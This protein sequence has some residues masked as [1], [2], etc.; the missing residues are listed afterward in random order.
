[1]ISYQSKAFNKFALIVCAVF[2]ALPAIASAGVITVQ[3][4][5]NNTKV[6]AGT[7]LNGNFNFGTQLIGQ[8]VD[9]LSVSANFKQ[10]ANAKYQS[11]TTGAEF[12]QSS[13]NFDY[14]CGWDTCKGKTEQYGRTD[15]VNN[16]DAAAAAT[17]K[18]GANAY[19]VANGAANFYD[20]GFIKT[21]VDKE[22]A[23]NRDDYKKYI[24][25][26]DGYRSTGYAGDFGFTFTLGAADIAALTASNALAFTLQGLSNSFNIS[27]I[28]LTA[29]TTEVP[30]PGS[31]MLLG[32]GV[33]GL[34]LARRR[35]SA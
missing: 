33:A 32:L 31:V 30:E 8:R 14:C 9:S 29:N 21:G 28:S 18:F 25:V 10:T 23:A 1:M 27:Q 24:N 16:F 2:G 7:T 17:L 15:T 22:T 5:L 35:K 6:N 11:T 34:L 13:T 19:S 20:T 4:N 26:I 12:F 3:S